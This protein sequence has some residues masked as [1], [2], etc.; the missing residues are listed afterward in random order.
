[1]QPGSRE[2]DERQP[3]VRQRRAGV[4]RRRLIGSVDQTRRVD[5][6]APS[7]QEALNRITYLAG[8]ALEATA[9]CAALVDTERQLLTSSFGLPVPTALLLSHAFRKQVLSTRRPLVV[10]DGRH[11]PVVG[12]NPAVRDGTV[13]A[14][15]GLPLGT[16]DG[17][18]VGTL[19][20]L[21]R[22]P[23]Q[24]TAPQLHL[25]RRLSTLIVDL[26]E[27][28]PAMRGVAQWRHRWS[29]RPMPGDPVEVR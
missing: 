20:V 5:L 21:D 24:W 2:P 12:R 10:A 25:L 6:P 15:V 19:L 7:V 23:R 4:R 3:V 16:A 29:G 18:A 28:G 26:M 11:D 8:E 13:R 27:L 14:C 1:M 22:R 17:R 9:V